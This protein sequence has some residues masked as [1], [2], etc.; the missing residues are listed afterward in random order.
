MIM[1]SNTHNN[2]CQ[3]KLNDINCHVYCPIELVEILI[4]NLMFLILFIFYLIEVESE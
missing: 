3:L 4:H 2:V 1:S